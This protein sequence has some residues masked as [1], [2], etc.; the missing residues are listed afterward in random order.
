MVV[1]G[2]CCGIRVG[3]VVLI[4]ECAVVVIMKENGWEIVEDVVDMV[5]FV[6]LWVGGHICILACV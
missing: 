3:L 1:V 6:E 4:V 5:V 2:W